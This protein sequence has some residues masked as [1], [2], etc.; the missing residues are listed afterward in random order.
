MVIRWDGLRVKDL[1]GYE[2]TIVRTRGILK[3]YEGR[4]TPK[5]VTRTVTSRGG[6]SLSSPKGGGG[7]PASPM[8]FVDCDPVTVS[9]LCLRFIKMERKG[10]A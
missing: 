3:G 5:P 10:C 2:V 1:K 9:Y 8:D 6:R 7:E 4:L